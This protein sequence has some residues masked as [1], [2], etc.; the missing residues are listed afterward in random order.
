MTNNQ[1]FREKI[2]EE[3]ILLYAEKKLSETELVRIS[4]LIE[5]DSE[6]SEHISILESLVAEQPQRKPSE[7][8]DKK[9][10]NTLGIKPKNFIE[11]ILEKTDGLLEVIM[12]NNYFQPELS[13]IP[14]L[15]RNSGDSYKV[16]STTFSNHPIFVEIST[17]D[18]T[19]IRLIIKNK[20][21]KHQFRFKISAPDKKVFDILADDT[22]S[23][24]PIPIDCGSYNIVVEKNSILLGNI[25]VTLK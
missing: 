5:N 11:I 16:F 15:V 19:Y 14:V 18:T 3:E 20:E 10:L 2:T 12:G 22:G 8:L 23:T 9:V 1:N 25:Q 4:K 17:S 21:K 24:K 6:L 7:Y 13:L